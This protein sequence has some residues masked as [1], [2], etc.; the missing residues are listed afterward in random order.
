M[1]VLLPSQK[2]KFEYLPGEWNLDCFQYLWKGF[3]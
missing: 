3:Q 1:D 2:V